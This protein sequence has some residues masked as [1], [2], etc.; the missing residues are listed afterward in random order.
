MEQNKD[1]MRRYMAALDARDYAALRSLTADEFTFHGFGVTLHGPESMEQFQHSFLEAFPDL[2]FPIDDLLVEGDRC[3]CRY[4]MWGTH[5]GAFMGTPATGKRIDI[6]GTCVSRIADGKLV[7]SWEDADTLGLLQQINAAPSAAGPIAEQNK[8]VMKRWFEAFN[9]GRDAALAILDETVTSDYVMRDPSGDLS[10]REALRQF[11]SMLFD[12]MPDLQMSLDDM[13][14]EKDRLAYQFAIRGTHTGE[15]MGFA[16]TGRQVQSSVTSIARFAD[17]KMAEETQTWDFHG[18]LQ[19]LSATEANKLLARRFF[20]DVL[21]KRD[22]AVA[23]EICADDFVFRGW[24][25]P[26]AQGWQGIRLIWDAI[27]TSFANLHYLVRD[28]IAE[29]DRVVVYWTCPGT[30]R[31]E[32]MGFSA[33]GKP[34]SAEGTTTLRISAGKIVE[35]T[36]HWDALGLLQ[37]IGAWSSPDKARAESAG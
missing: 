4:R 19:Q 1:V 29:G 17:R 15:L 36:G 9:Q 25:L 13:V 26:E 27:D 37:S 5:T 3:A 16:P 34:G 31:G 32:F 2:Q 28:M 33:T 14:A 24:H 10:G 22:W 11:I 8:A 7:E 21:N 20:E 6:T 18:F 30:S 12:G 23:Q 35:H